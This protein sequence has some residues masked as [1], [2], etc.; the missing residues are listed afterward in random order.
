MPPA[1]PTTEYGTRGSSR[2]VRR[3]SGAVGSSYVISTTNLD[4]VCQW[5]TE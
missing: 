1:S 3:S 4:L 5:M 2:Y